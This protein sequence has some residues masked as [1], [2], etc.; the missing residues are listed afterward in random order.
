MAKS[1]IEITEKEYL[2]KLNKS[3]FEYPLVR[4]LLNKLLNGSLQRE[5]G[6]S[7]DEIT[8]RYAPELCERFDLLHDK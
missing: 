3:E 8:A 7:E 2:I 4:R 6:Y 5:L 1:T